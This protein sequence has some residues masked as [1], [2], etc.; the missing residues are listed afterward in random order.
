M[1]RAEDLSARL[2]SG[3]EAAI[4]ELI[5]ER[6][7]EELFLDFKRS[8]DNGSGTRL[9]DTDRGNLARAISGFGNSEGGVV[10]WGVDCRP[11]QE[12]GDVAVAD[13][14]RVGSKMQFQ[15]SKFPHILKSGTSPLKAALLAQVLLS[16]YSQELHGPTLVHSTDAF[17]F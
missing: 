9:S 17:R 6:Q 3:G 5:Q 14:S 12:I 13:A 1:G 4:D 15:V 2:S 8:S 7:S 16:L 10:V 11:D